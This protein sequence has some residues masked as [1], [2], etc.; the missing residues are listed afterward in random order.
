MAKKELNF[1]KSLKEL[2]KYAEKIKD[3]NLTLDQSI[4]CYE[5]GM[6]SY[7]ECKEILEKAKITIKNYNEAFDIEE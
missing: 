5:K 3:G 7:E 6:K 1:E 4:E 2:K